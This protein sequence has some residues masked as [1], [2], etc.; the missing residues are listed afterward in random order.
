MKK[1]MVTAWEIARGAV[2]K[3]GGKAVEYLAMALKMAWAEYKKGATTVKTF[4][5][6]ETLSGSRN[7][8]TWVARI[9][10]TCERYGYKREFVKAADEWTGGKEFRLFNGNVYDVCNGG[11]RSMVKVVDGE[12]IAI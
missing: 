9:V 4:A 6:L 12:I 2:N 1:V 7:H 8:K 3:F 11:V 5:V 10:G